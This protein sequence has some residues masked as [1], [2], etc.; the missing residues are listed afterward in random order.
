M[1]ATDIFQFDKNIPP[2]LLPRIKALVTPLACLVPK[3][4]QVVEINYC[5]Y[6]VAND[7]EE[8]TNARA[9]I[10]YDYREGYIKVYPSFF[11]HT[12]EDQEDICVHEFVHLSNSIAVD[13][14]MG[15]LLRLLAGDENKNYR[16]SVMAQFT[17]HIESTTQDMCW[18]VRGLMNE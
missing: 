1:K 17:N 10:S 6:P 4:C 13:Y 3:W 14:A 15:E 9:S 11:E 12:P 2:E 5:G 18:I 8:N 16:E 7:T